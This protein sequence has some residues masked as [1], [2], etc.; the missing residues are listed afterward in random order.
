MFLKASGSLYRFRFLISLIVLILAVVFCS[1]DS[2]KHEGTSRS[3]SYSRLPPCRFEITSDFLCFCSVPVGGFS[4][5][6]W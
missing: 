2:Q 4:R 5:R 1:E 6:H 3:S